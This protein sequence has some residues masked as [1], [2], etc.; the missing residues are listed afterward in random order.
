MDFR[1]SPAEAEFRAQLR[2]WL[3]R[4]APGAGRGWSRALY[5][6]GYAGLTWPREYGGGGLTPNFEAIYHEEAAAANVPTPI[7]FIGLNIAGPTIIAWGTDE[8]KRRFLP[9]L[10]SGEQVWCQG[11]SEPEAGS[12]LAGA[13]TRA[14]RD[15]DHWVVNG[16][17]VW[18][19][20]AHVADWCVLLARTDPD[21][22]KHAGLSYLLVDMR[23]PGVEVRPLRQLTGESEFNEIFFT[24]VR[25]P[26][27]LMLGQP[28]DGWKVAMTTLQHE[29]GTAALPLAAD[30][31]AKL[32][33]LLVLSSQAR[34]DGSVPSA[35]PLV[36]Q[37]IARE[38]VTTQALRFT[39]Y[40]SLTALLH[41]GAPGPEAMITRLAW[42]QANQ[43]LTRLALDVQGAYAAID[44]DDAD[45][46]G[47]WQH[48]QLRSRGNTIEGGTAEIQRNVIAERVLNLPRGR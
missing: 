48:E 36:R 46:H 31:Q 1:D 8:Q 45:W 28:G 34:P 42:S 41:D 37:A 47:Y 24:D 17:K 44:G 12:D 35:D 40:R 16:Q 4:N 33:H 43:R 26:A 6:A 27:D 11:F 2:E 18:S 38:W 21:V 15:G 32:H 10:L 29:R 13:R 23:S 5:D 39:N 7:N 9:P 22:A 3:Q 19:S 20:L 30:L 14:V 25:V